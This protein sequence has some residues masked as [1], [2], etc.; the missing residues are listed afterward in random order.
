MGKREVNVRDFMRDMQG[1]MDDFG[2]MK[3][4]KLTPKGLDS[5]F[6]KLLT[7]GLI[8]HSELAARTNGQTDT[9]DLAGVN[10]ARLEQDGP[11]R[12]Q[13]K[14]TQYMYSGKV[15]GVDI[16]DYVQWMLVEGRQTVLEVAPEDGM[17]CR[18]YINDGTILHVETME[19]VGEE[20][21]YRLARSPGGKFCHLPWTEPERITIERAGMQLLFE[22]ARLRDESDL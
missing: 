9:I 12:L 2:F 20:A 17:P 10:T 11:R 16:L 6:R 15:E 21:F 14:R 18:L 5:A 8:S 19:M 22:A 4:Y 1:G 13:R 7:A 3:K